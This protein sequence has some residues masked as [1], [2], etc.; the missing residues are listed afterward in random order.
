[1]SSLLKNILF[2]LALAVILWIGYKL[3]IAPND[4][5]LTPL[6]A[7]VAS[8]ASR[9]TQE[10]LQ[11]LQQLRDITLDGTVFDD[12]RFQSLVD[13]RQTITPEPVGR[14]NPFAPIGK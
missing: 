7:T 9:D 13:F 8:Q 1:M 10:F 3:F 12:A 14:P 11:T 2:A 6:D 4:A 5:S